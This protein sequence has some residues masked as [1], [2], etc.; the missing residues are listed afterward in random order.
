MFVTLVDSHRML[1]ALYSLSRCI[2][3]VAMAGATPR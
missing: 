2:R 1:L 3:H